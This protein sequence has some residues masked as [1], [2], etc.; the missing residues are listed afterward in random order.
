MRAMRD[1]VRAGA[2]VAALALGL[3]VAHPARAAAASIYDV[4][5]DCQDGV[6]DGRYSLKDLRRAER[7]LPSD[8]SEYSDCVDALR[9][10]QVS[11]RE[12]RSS[13]GSSG[14]PGGAPGGHE[15]SPPSEGASG[16]PSGGAAAPAPA[17]PE[18]VAA[19]GEEIGK[20]AGQGPPAVSVGGTQL[21]PLAPGAATALSAGEVVSKLPPPVLLAML[22][23]GALCLLVLAVLLRFRLP[24]AQRLA[25][26]LRRR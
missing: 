13:G 17:P 7:S 14:A 3:G 22:V 10:A 12:R 11:A 6:V 18:D 4:I 19:L 15:P 1:I 26:R 25:L 16:M 5:R 9:E 21:T 8:Q 23:I 20:I 24:G 2:V